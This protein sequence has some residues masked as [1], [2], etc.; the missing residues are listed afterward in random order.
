MLAV[1][2]VMIMYR[3][4]KTAPQETTQGTHNGHLR[5]HHGDPH[6]GSPQEIPPGDSRG[7]SGDPL[8]GGGGDPLGDPPGCVFRIMVAQDRDRFHTSKKASS[9]I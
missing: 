9:M 8:G 2:H 1:A 4:A 6:R 7:G 3:F 5:V